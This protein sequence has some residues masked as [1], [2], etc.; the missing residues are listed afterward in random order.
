MVGD[1][2]FSLSSFLSALVGWGG[3]AITTVLLFRSRLDVAETKFIGL[4]TRLREQ[5]NEDKERLEDTLREIRANFDRQ[6]QQLSTETRRVSE[7]LD[8]WTREARSTLGE[9]QHD[10]RRREEFML[11]LLVGIAAKEGV[12]HRITDALAQLAHVEQ[13]ETRRP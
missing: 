6:C 12:R 13:Q 8:A 7:H 1:I 11:E 10:S 4:E 9:G 2:G 3:G 5:R